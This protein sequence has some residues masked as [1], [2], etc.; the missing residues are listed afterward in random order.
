MTA[1]FQWITRTLPFRRT[2]ARAVSAMY[3]NL[4]GNGCC[5]LVRFTASADIIQ[6]AM[7]MPQQPI[8]NLMV[9]SI[10]ALRTASSNQATNGQKKKPLPLWQRQEIQGALWKR[11]R[12]RGILALGQEVPQ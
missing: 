8:A 3:N 9:A 7:T 1:R 11:I 5:A 12:Q 2:A 10:F 4:S 6:N